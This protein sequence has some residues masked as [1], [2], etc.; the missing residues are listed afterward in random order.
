[1]AKFSHSKLILFLLQLLISLLSTAAAA[2]VRRH[3][4][5]P[6]SPDE[7]D[8]I[9][10]LI[11]DSLP[12]PSTTNVTF[13][14]VALA[15]PDKQSLLSWLSNPK[16]PPPP[17]HATAIVRYNSSTHEILIDLD[18]KVIISNQVYS[19]PAYSLITS[20]EQ[21]A[22]AALPLSHPPFVAA[23]KKRGLKMEEVV[24]G[25]FSVG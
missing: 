13:Q 1:M 21:L 9:R 8:L 11:T 12:N 10:S 16:T 24:C 6:L 22:A 5:D 4:L 19:G 23:M 15:D 3:P 17:R 18:K 14:Y 25:S 2:A 20:N 7:F